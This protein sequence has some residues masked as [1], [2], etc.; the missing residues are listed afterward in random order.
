VNELALARAMDFDW[1]LQLSSVWED[2]PYDTPELHRATRVQFESELDAM[3]I[4]DATRNPTGWVVTGRGGAGKTH[5]LSS[6]RASTT[7]REAT[8]VLVDMTDVRDFWDL[9]LQSYIHSIQQPVLNNDTQLDKIL[10]AIIDRMRPKNRD[11][12]EILEILKNRPA[13]LLAKDLNKIVQTLST[14]DR[15]NTII[16]H[17]VLR[18]MICLNHYWDFEIRGIGF[19]W[20]QGREI[21]ESERIAYG[22]SKRSK[23]PIEIVRGLSWLSSLRGPVVLAFDQLDAIV[24]QYN[25]D[26]R[27]KRNGEQAVASASIIHQIGAGLGSL[28][29]QTFNTLSII[30]CIEST[31]EI[32]RTTIP[33]AFLDRFHAP[34]KLDSPSSADK[35]VERLISNRL[36]IAFSKL[37]FTPPYPTW[38]FKPA[39]IA[40]LKA[41]TPREIF[42][43]CERWRDQWLTEGFVFEV[44]SFDDK[45]KPKTVP[46]DRSLPAH[47]RL[48]ELFQVQVRQAE[49]DFLLEEKCDDERLAP[50]IQDA[51]VCLV[52]EIDLPRNLGVQ[53]DPYFKKGADVPPL[54]A[55]LRIIH[56][57]ENEREEH[58]S[59]RFLQWNNARAFQNRLKKATTQAG[60]DA[61]LPFRRLAI[62]RTGPIPGG[63]ETK[64]LVDHFLSEGGVFIEPSE[65]EIRSLFAIS[66]LKQMNDPEFV[67]WLRLRK[68]LSGLK[69]MRAA[70]PSPLVTGEETGTS[71]STSDVKPISDSESVRSS[72]KAID[73]SGSV[74]SVTTISH[75]NAEVSVRIGEQASTPQISDHFAESTPKS[76]PAALTEKTLEASSDKAPADLTEKSPLASIEQAPAS[77]ISQPSPADRSIGS[78]FDSAPGVAETQ[79]RNPI[80]PMNG[81]HETPA[82]QSRIAST[83]P[84]EICFGLKIIAGKPEERLNGSIKLL[85][86][87]VFVVAGA[88][89]GKSVLLRRIV[90]QAA[91]AG[92][93]SIVIDAANDMSSLDERRLVRPEGWI[94]GDEERAAG[95]HDRTDVVV[96]TP[97]RETGNPLSFEP[98]PD[99]SAAGDDGD[100]IE[101]MISMA[102][103]SLEPIVAAGKGV[104]IDRKKAILSKALRR[105]S[106]QGLNSLDRLIELL[107]DLPADV[108]LGLSD[109]GKLA[110]SMADSIKSQRE[111]NPMLR[112]SGAP[113]DPAILFGDDGGFEKTRISVVNL[114]GLASLDSKQVF[115]N[116]LAMT[117]FGWI[118]KHPAP[119][120]A[121]RGLLIVD[122]AKDFAPSQS[123]S[124]CKESLA[125]LAAQARKYHLGVIF[126]TQNPKDIDNRIVSNCATHYYGRLNSPAAIDAV[127]ELIRQKGGSG[128]DVSRLTP[129]TFRVHN[130]ELNLREPVKV[131]VPNCL[132]LHRDNPLEGDEIAAKARACRERIAGKKAN[133]SHN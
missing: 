98:L 83:S 68:P 100:E 93:P 114:E 29:D 36:A 69:L 35:V 55:R 27:I 32:L 126:A 111:T 103:E 90:E 40:E 128:G 116:Q 112:S 119:G 25:V 89:S 130:A 110:K 72:S 60:I 38:P 115:I 71:G 43:L 28:R 92:V 87:H 13:D 51:L 80:V 127:D 2:S 41:N 18:A 94:E 102:R 59:I 124:M 21:E 132:S 1:V 64:K 47:A 86:K 56:L 77:S 78:V 104:T 121:L 96:W 67:S 57:D 8:F 19:T 129:G 39:A 30:T 48:D 11:S 16:H 34:R 106:S 45:P 24:T 58:F 62:V 85:E 118:K 65:D 22:F 61:A 49:V 15:V 70:V 53:V 99:F 50:L 4:K 42:Q 79:R 26:T 75:A 44:E 107:D 108:G 84:P 5:L 7:A 6:F 3:R 73:S 113:L 82:S 10:N 81:A 125:R 97:G 31:W 17:D 12:A 54:H 46:V 14:Y 95:Y 37:D 52:Q 9:V 101:T 105:L 109:E 33:R 91:I 66:K 133:A 20:L 131:F 117:L 74:D 123:A 23:P 63:A 88:G 122:E 76:S 120:R